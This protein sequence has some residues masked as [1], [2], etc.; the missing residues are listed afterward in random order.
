MSATFSA[1]IRSIV[2]TVLPQEKPSDPPGAQASQR[3]LNVCTDYDCP[4]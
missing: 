3:G 2:A 1:L 4:G